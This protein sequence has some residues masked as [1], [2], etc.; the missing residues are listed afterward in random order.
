LHLIL[1]NTSP[2]SVKKTF[3]G[4][5]TY[6]GTRYLG[7]QKTSFG[8]TI[9][10][11]VEKA[12]SL[13]LRKETFVEAASRTDGGVHARGQVI[14]FFTE[15]DIEV[16]RFLRSVNALL[17]KDIALLHLEQ[18]ADDFHSTLDALYKEYHYLLSIGPAQP[19]FDR[20]F[21][22]HVPQPL[23]I[24]AM[25]DCA[26]CLLGEHDFSAFCNERQLLEVD[27]VCQL[28]GLFVEKLNDFQMRIRTIGNRFLYRMVRNLVGTL[29]Y[30]GRGKIP[31]SGL[32][33]I[34][35]AKMRA[36]AGVTAPAHGLVLERIVYDNA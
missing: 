22:W 5:L 36:S 4:L 12:L 7:W 25:Q 27:P 14:H 8:P 24:S 29:V 10:G 30:V 26:H 2:L 3:R 1:K 13:L 20:F 31:V 32:P 18:A 11:E 23:D 33:G 17:P 28:H 9:Q 34:L 19:P 16:G 6:E 15:S 21:S 35:Q